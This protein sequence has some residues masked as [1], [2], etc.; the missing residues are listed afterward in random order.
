[1][2]DFPFLQ[3]GKGRKV[4]RGSDIE[5]QE[6]LLDQ[7]TRVRQEQGDLVPGTLEVPLSNVIFRAFLFGFIFVLFIFGGKTLQL[8]LLSGHDLEMRAQRNAVKTIP[9]LADRGIIYDRN[10]QPLVLNISTFEYVCDKREL[11]QGLPERSRVLKNIAS[12]IS[13]SLSEIQKRFDATGEPETVLKTHLVQEEIVFLQTKEVTSACRV[14][15]NKVREYPYG[16]LLSHVIGYTAKVSSED[17][18]G[19]REYFVVEQIGKTGLEKTYE[20]IL[21]GTPGVIRMERDSSGEIIQERE[22]TKPQTGFSLALWLDLELQKK[23]EEGLSTSLANTNTK[24]AAA[25]ILNP[26][27]GG[28]LAMASYP[29]FDPNL[30][31][32]GILQKEWDAL[33]LDPAKPLFNRAIGG[34]GYPTGSVIKPLVALQGLEKGVIDED[35]SIY[36]PLEICVWNRYAGRDECFRDWTFHGQSDVKRAIAESVNTFFYIIGGGYEGRQGLGP[37]SIKE[38]LEKFGWNQKTGID[39]FGEGQ[40]VL[41]DITQQWRLGDTYHLS[42][43]QGVFSITPLQVASAFGAIANGGQLLQPQMVHQVLDSHKNV[44]EEFSPHVL[45][46]NLADPENLNVVRE[47]MR[48]TVTTGSATGFLDALPV[49]A[50]AKTGTAQTGRKTLGG[51]DYLYS[52]IVTFAPFDHP[53]FLMVVAVEDVAEGNAA[54]LPVARDVMQWYFSN[55]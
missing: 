51:K 16:F 45:K 46:S 47:G 17:L 40:G 48:Q 36:A 5:P 2:E 41:P 38:V 26:Q 43:G 44:V 9:Q 8:Q 54:S 10:M 23:L 15:E 4:K 1:M 12:A 31:S 52:W 20:E 27:T 37:E 28:V 42:I 3:K 24:K 7:L 34:F 21:R 25:V 32:Q 49:A 39:L 50:A 30:F 18:E 35:T 19:D 14:E 55:K 29:S 6:I 53:D 13:I 22:R 33:R 11:P